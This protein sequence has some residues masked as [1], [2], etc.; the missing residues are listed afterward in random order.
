MEKTHK[1]YLDGVY[2][3]YGY[4]FGIIGVSGLDQNKIYLGGVPLL[5]SDDGG[6]T[7][8]NIGDAN[9]HSDHQAL[10]VN[11]NKAGHVVNGNDG[12]INI[13]FDDG[14]NWSKNNPQAVGQFY[15][16]NV[17]NKKPY[18]VYGGLQDNGVWY[19]PSNYRFSKGWEGRGSYPYKAIGGGDGMQV[20]ID[21]RDN[22]TVYSGSQFG[23]YYR[24]NLK[25]RERISIHPKH[26]LGDSP[27]RYNWQTPIL[28]SPHNQ[29]ILYMG[30]N[31]KPLGE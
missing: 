22:E 28:L 23:Y 16:I 20:Q 6:K 12:G 21:N 26:E 15:A 10:W 30:A 13:T 19:G 25:T 5:K 18:N 27:Y 8:S 3:S 24:I 14:E 4:Y 11:P 31:K 9:M 2:S 1:G 17:D 7:F 29:D